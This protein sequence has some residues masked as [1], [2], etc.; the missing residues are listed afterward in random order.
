MNI[1]EML[2]MAEEILGVPA[3]IT[4]Y[5]HEGRLVIQVRTSVSGVRFAGEASLT[6]KE[7]ERGH[8]DMLEWDFRS[9][10]MSVKRK[11]DDA[12]QKES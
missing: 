5:K 9:T 6:K 7:L 3:E 1:M 12:A 2:N 4:T 11:I 8:L 10:L